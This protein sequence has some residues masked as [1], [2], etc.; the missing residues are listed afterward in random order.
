MAIIDFN[1]Y[2]TTP[3]TPYAP[4]VASQENLAPNT[5]DTAPLT[6]PISNSGG[7]TPGYNAGVS[8]NAG[9]DLGIGGEMWLEVLIIVAVAQ[10]S[11]GMNFYLVTDATATLASVASQTG[12]GVL[13]ESPAFTAAQ[14]KAQSYWR[15][16][17]PASG[18]YLEFIG[19][20]AYILTNNWTAGSFEAKLLTNIQQSDLYQSGFALQ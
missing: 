10:T 4:T 5:I 15:T 11:G 1:N 14:L 7:S 9:R 6:L 17:L 2:F 18:G 19:L 12:V 20:D 13:L 3:G 8:T 16:Q